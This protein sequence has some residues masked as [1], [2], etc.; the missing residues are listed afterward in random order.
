MAVD[1]LVG[2][3][4]HVVRDELLHALALCVLNRVLLQVRESLR[5]AR[6]ILDQDVITRDQGFLLVLLRLLLVL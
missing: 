3:V 1:G 4:P 6:N 5:E 2:H